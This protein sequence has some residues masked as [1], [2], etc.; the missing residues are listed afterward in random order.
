[1]RAVLAVIL[2]L[3]FGASAVLYCDRDLVQSWKVDFCTM[4]G[5]PVSSWKPWALCEVRKHPKLE[6]LRDWALQQGK[7]QECV[8][9]EF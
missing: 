6:M 7:S 5:I 8:I 2:G 4:L 9:P 3:W 1:M